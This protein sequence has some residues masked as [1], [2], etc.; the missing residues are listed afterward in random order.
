MIF[1]AQKLAQ[2]RAIGKDTTF[3]IS[4]QA[5]P[6]NEVERYCRRAHL[7]LQAL[8]PIPQTPL[9]IEY[10]TPAASPRVEDGD[11]GLNAVS[12]DYEDQ[13]S[14]LLPHQ[15]ASK[16][17]ITEVTV[18]GTMKNPLLPHQNAT[19]HPRSLAL[20]SEMADIETSIR[21]VNILITSAGA[22][23]R[24]YWRSNHVAE[25]FDSIVSFIAKA[26]SI[27]RNL[28]LDYTVQTK[29]RKALNFI[30]E[31]L[32]SNVNSLQ[33]LLGM[34]LYLETCGWCSESTLILHSLKNK[35]FSLG[36]NHPLGLLLHALEAHLNLSSRNG[37]LDA[38]ISS[39]I[40]SGIANFGA[41]DENILIL[42][43]LKANYHRL[44]K[45]W[46][47]ALSQLETMTKILDQYKVD[48]PMFQFWSQR[49][50][51]FKVSALYKL[52]DYDEAKSA[53]SNVLLTLQ[54]LP[55]DRGYYSAVIE[56]SLFYLSIGNVRSAKKFLE[57]T[58]QW[59]I[60]SNILDTHDALRAYQLLQICHETEAEEALERPLAP[61]TDERN[62][63]Q[64]RADPVRH[65]TEVHEDFT[66]IDEQIYSDPEDS[67]PEEFNADRSDI[68]FA[69]QEL[70]T[71]TDLGNVSTSDQT[72]FL[73]DALPDFYLPDFDDQLDENWL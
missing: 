53:V 47:L 39:A 18:A 58:M 55:K 67:E 72:M 34:L 56:I 30:P 69:G 25:E 73:E 21:S 29:L 54:N 45:D 59:Y 32:L 48:S 40:Q 4:G 64:S 16:D 28:Q 23:D 8:S 60:K 35:A 71:F 19:N 50:L 10:T 22:S 63:L 51:T 15:R 46:K 36:K 33:T 66:D 65:Q 31:L 37:L 61:G 12:S 2:R 9:N 26:R 6:S 57:E 13:G 7:N 20:P 17:D 1:A 24:N 11:N 38:M 42:L 43:N 52:G 44:N 5:C 70:Q 14:E 3:T 62:H 27:H 68:E 41:T 49:I